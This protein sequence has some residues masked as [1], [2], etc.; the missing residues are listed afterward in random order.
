[1]NASS[2]A[3]RHA[4]HRLEH[5]PERRPARQRGMAVIAALVVVAAAAIAAAAILEDQALL[6]DTLTVERDRTDAKWIL[7][8]GLDWS[9]AILLDDARR[10]AVTRKNAVWA[11]PI[12]GLEIAT[13]DGMRKA[14]FSGQI[15]DEQGKYN[16]RRLAEQGAVQPR[17]VAV[18]R[19][20]LASLGMQESLAWAVAGRVAGAQGG[21]GRPRTLPGLRTLDDLAG[22]EGMSPG[23]AAAL[24]GYLTVLPQKTPINVNTASAEVLSAG[25]PGL[26]LGQARDLAGQRDRGQWF[27]DG[28]DFYQ[29]MGKAG[30]A[31]GH[32]VGVRSEWFKVTG[33]VVIHDTPVAMQALLHRQGDDPPVIQW[34][35]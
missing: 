21:P 25:I 14:Y 32:P 34:L 2:P 9:R 16:I 1:M 20:L 4:P 30:A 31:N 5:R 7:R 19:R 27:R 35:E 13:P 26:D 12:A 29:R 17:E 24:S 3:A 6:V 10:N 15:E 18:L 22:L 8:G 23:A 11:Q 33:Q 28:A